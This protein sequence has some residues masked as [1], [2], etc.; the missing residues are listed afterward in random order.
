[1]DGRPNVSYLR[2]VTGDMTKIRVD[3]RFTPPGTVEM[4]EFSS[5]RAGNKAQLCYISSKVKVNSVSLEKQLIE[6][7]SSS[8]EKEGSSKPTN[9]RDNKIEKETKEEKKNAYSSAS[10]NRSLAPRDET[11]RRRSGSR[12]QQ[13][14]KNIK[15]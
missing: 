9:K 2:Q 10:A 6:A 8:K 5:N 7:A 1:M 12:H 13:K 4:T 3:F 15:R 11:R 14:D